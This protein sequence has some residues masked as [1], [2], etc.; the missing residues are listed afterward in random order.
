[1]ETPSDAAGDSN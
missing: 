1:M